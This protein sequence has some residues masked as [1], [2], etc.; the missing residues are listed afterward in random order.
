[1]THYM[2]LHPRPF[3]M[4]KNKIKTVEMRL[5]DEKRKTIKI[6]DLIEFT[7][8]ETSETIK[9]KVVDLKAYKDFSLLYK[10]Y[11]KEEIGYLEDEVAN[12]Q[13]MQTYYS[14]EKINQ[15]GAIA[16]RIKVEV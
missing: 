2:N 3:K 6:N 16:I 5:N 1:M 12:P 4:I 7:N 13:D 10:E 9:V 14:Q 11:S 8:I 15:Y